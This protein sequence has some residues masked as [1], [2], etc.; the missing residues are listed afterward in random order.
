MMA[1]CKESL[2]PRQ[3][4]N[5][6]GST[7]QSLMKSY[8]WAAVILPPVMAFWIFGFQLAP[9]DDCIWLLHATQR[10]LAGGRYFYDVLE[11][12]PPIV[13]MVLM[14]PAALASVLELNA[15]PV[16][17]AYIC[18]LIVL[19]VVLCLPFWRVLSER[20]GLSMPVLV[21]GS[22]L[23]LTFVPGMEF[24]QREHLAILLTL[25]AIF[26]FALPRAEKPRISR[27]LSYIIAA[28]AAV[29]FCIKPY[30]LI[31]P[32]IGAGFYLWETRNWRVVWTGPI[33]VFMATGLCIA[34]IAVLLFTEWLTHVMPLVRMAYGEYRTSTIKALVL[35]I[36]AFT[37]IAAALTVIELTQPSKTLLK[38]C[39]MIGLASLGYGLAAAVQMRGWGY[40]LIPVITLGCIMAVLA[41]AHIWARVKEQ[42]L[43]AL[44][45][46]IAAAA[47]FIVIHPTMVDLLWHLQNRSVATYLNRPISR[48]VIEHSDGGSILILSPWMAG[49]FPLALMAGSDWGSRLAHR[50]LI[51]RIIRLERGGVAD[52]AKAAYLKQ[53]EISMLTEDLGR[54]K[55]HVVAVEVGDGK[56]LLNDGFEYLPFYQQS[57]QFRAEWQSYKLVQSLKGWDVYQRRN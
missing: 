44:S 15:Y 27:I 37:I 48:A 53:L 29:G 18:T 30:F 39:R 4:T 12:N 50:W 41:A 52:R 38:T 32:L 2:V 14:P 6:A 10:L 16:F 51:P 31:V 43:P 40:H 22:S 56:V 46:F 47:A 36:Q 55:P 28:L 34:G 5:V 13:N 17:I 23:A 7:V 57:E 42:V 9:N 20:A 1:V 49:G 54:F 19:S 8:F 11:V 21:V 26:A 24:G 35:E 3:N 45:A 25:P 33:L